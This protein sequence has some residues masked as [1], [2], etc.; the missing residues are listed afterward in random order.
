MRFPCLLCVGD[1]SQLA[2]SPIAASEVVPSALP[3]QRRQPSLH[4]GAA[5]ILAAATQLANA[6][7][8]KSDAL[9]SIFLSLSHTHTH[10]HTHTVGVQPSLSVAY[11]SYSLWV[12]V[13]LVHLRVCSIQQSALLSR[14]DAGKAAA[15]AP[16][17]EE[18][19]K[20]HKSAVDQLAELVMVTPSI[21]QVG[22]RPSRATH[23][24]THAHTHTHTHTHTTHRDTLI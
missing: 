4:G 13:F 19:G 1:V 2:A 22:P 16:R 3:P 7:A 18:C 21:Q 10:T 24:H 15:T 8:G 11:V 14:G 17:A 5:A 6:S 23:T 20:E 9:L 12:Y